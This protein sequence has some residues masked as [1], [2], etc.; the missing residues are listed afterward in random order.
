MS[1]ERFLLERK[2]N[3]I[4]CRGT[5]NR[6]GTCSGESGVRNLEAESIRSRADSTTRGCVKLNTITEI[7]RSNA[8][9]TFIAQSVY[10]VLNSLLDW[11]PM[12]KLKQRCDV[13]SFMFF[14]A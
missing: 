13:V 2:G 6:K 11:Q 7:R 3:F 1:P 10:L 4:P 8:R 9:D 12:K 14:S 5:K